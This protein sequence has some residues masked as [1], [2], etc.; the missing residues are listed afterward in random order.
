VLLRGADA[1]ALADALDA[2]TPTNVIAA[3]RIVLNT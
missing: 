3:T 1:R 2:L